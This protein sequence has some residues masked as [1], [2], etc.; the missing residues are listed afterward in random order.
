MRRKN[1]Y[2]KTYHPNYER[3][4]SQALREIIN[5]P[6]SPISPL[7]DREK[8]LL[9][10]EAPAEYRKPWF[11]QLMAAPQ[12]MAYLIQVNYWLEKYM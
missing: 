10:L 12:L 9:F 6:N 1:P 4:L 3:L 11:G 8:T 7:I 2:P 5:D